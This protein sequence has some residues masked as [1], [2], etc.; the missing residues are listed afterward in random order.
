MSIHAAPHRTAPA[1]VDVDVRHVWL[2]RVAGVR[3]A[4]VLWGGLLLTDLTRL[5]GA[6]SY[7]GLAGLAVLVAAA[8]VGMRA[9]TAFGAGVVGTL[10]ANGFLVHRLGVLQYDGAG[11]LARLAL[12]VGV[13]VAATRLRR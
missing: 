3:L 6:P 8:S 5:T 2:A 13:A 9:Y 11:D 4:V 12:L 1:R 7:V 10:L